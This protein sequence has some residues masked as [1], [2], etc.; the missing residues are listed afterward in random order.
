MLQLVRSRCDR[1]NTAAVVV[2]HELNLAAEFSDRV[3]LLKEGQSVGFGNPLETLTAESL[4]SV[5]GLQVLVDAH[6]ISGAQR[7]TPVF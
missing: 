2:T 1:D 7:I 5:F 4:T 3:L 6:P